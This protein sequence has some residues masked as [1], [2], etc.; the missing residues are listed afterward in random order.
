MSKIVL[1]QP[2]SSCPYRKDVPSGVWDARE[3]VKLPA[4]DN[5]T[6]EQPMQA[7]N[8]H[9]QNGCLCRGWLD[10]H[11]KQ[12]PGHELM[13]LRLLGL[14]VGPEGVAEIQKAIEDGPAVPVFEDGL[15]ACMHGLKEIQEPSDDAIDVQSK[16]TAVH[17]KKAPKC[18][19]C[20]RSKMPLTSQDHWCPC[21]QE[22]DG[23]EEYVT[24]H[25]RWQEFNDIPDYLC[26]YRRV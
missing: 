11:G 23:S 17:R 12:K 7:F 5:P 16:V 21:D 18:P 10:V 24:R 25:I 14:S 26:K 8:C 15:T 22:D 6:G 3:Y 20:T 2:C 19:T 13:S 1:S 9:Q 4:Y